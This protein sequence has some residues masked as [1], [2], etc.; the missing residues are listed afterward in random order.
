LSPEQLYE[1]GQIVKEGPEEGGFDTGMWSASL[2]R[3][4]IKSL[5]GVKYSVSH[6]QRLLHKLGFSV[7]KPSQLSSKADEDRR[8]DWIEN[9]LPEIQ[10]KASAERAALI[11]GDEASFQ[12]SGSV[13]QTWALK[14]QGCEV[15]TFPTRKSVKAFGAVRL[16]NTPKWHF[17][18][19]EK[20]NGESFI[21]FLEQLVR[22][23]SEPK[24]Y[25]ITDNASYHKSP[26]VK[27]W[28]SDHRERIEIHYLPPYSPD[29]NAVEYVWR[30]TK[31]MTTHNRFFKT[32]KELREK[33]F[34]R[35]NRFQG[36]PSAIRSTVAAFA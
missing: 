24:I 20:F 11:H 4:L 16:G 29:F 13:T 32:L 12:Q 34:R 1:L 30:R 10:E 5:F 7:Q 25:F 31:R 35:F 15:M 22:Q 27:K 14:G 26:P 2:L 23:Y 33:L 8:K 17:R 18:F 21:E 19:A 28:L 3:S 36:N 6:V 9:E